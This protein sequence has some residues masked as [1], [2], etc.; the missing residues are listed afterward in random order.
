MLPDLAYTVETKIG[1]L[2]ISP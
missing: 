2:K 1:G